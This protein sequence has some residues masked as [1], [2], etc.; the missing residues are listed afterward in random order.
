MLPYSLHEVFPLS[1]AISVGGN[2]TAPQA[3]RLWMQGPV[4]AGSF[5]TY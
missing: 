1:L 5:P 3:G 2:L 4:P